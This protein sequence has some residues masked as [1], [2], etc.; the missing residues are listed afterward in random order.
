[1]KYSDLIH[2]EPIN[3][4]VKFSRTSELDYQQNLVKTFV[5]SKAY[6]ESLIP[7]IGKILDYTSN[8]EGFGM[9]VV[10]NYGT[11]KSHMMSLVSL[12]AENESLL[13]LV[14]EERPK[15]YLASFAGRYKV[16]R[17]ELGYTESLWE[18]LTYKI[19]NYL[20]TLGIDFS[21]EG[22]GVKSYAERIQLMMAEFEEHYPD[23]GFLVVIDEMLAYLK[24]RSEPS[25]L[26]QDLQV[27]QALGQAADA[28]KFR[29]IFGVQEMIYHSPEFQF[30]ADMLQKVRD[31]Y[32]DIIITKDDVSFIVKHRLLKKSEHQKKKIKD[33]LEPFLHLFTDMHGRTDEYIELFPVHPSY[34]ENFQKI[35]IG[36]SQREILKTLS[37]QFSSLLDE[38]IPTDHPGLICYDQYW[39]DI[40][41]SPDLMTIPDVRRV[42]EIS[43]TIFDKIDA[44]FIG[45]RT[46]RQS[47]AKRIGCA[48]AIKI[49]Q[50]ELNQQNGVNREQLVD[51][52]C[53]TAP[54]MHERELLIDTVDTT[55]LHIITATSGQFFD[56]NPDN[57]EYHLRIEGGIN[58][59]QKIKDYAATMS[60]SQKD[61]Y[62][63]KFLENILPLDHDPYRTGFKIWQHQIEW[64]SHKTYREG[65]IFFGDPNE[66]STT[67]PRQYFYLYFMPIFDDSKKQRNHEA[68][69][70]YF[71]LD[72]LSDEFRQEI[73]LY[74]AAM[75][76]EGRADTSQKD[77][78]KQKI[79]TLRDKARRIFEEEYLQIT[80][81]DYLGE[82]RPLNAFPLP[83]EGASKEHLF[84]EVAAQLLEN[85]FEETNP[86]YPRF[87]LLTASIAKDNFPRLIK[88]A[89]LKIAK[90]Q[91][92]NRDGEGI[93][94][95]LGLWQ[96]GK[97]DISQSIYAKSL[98]RKLQEKGEGKVLNREEIL[99]CKWMQGNLWLSKDF[100]I[101]AELEFLVMATLSALGEIEITFSSG[102]SINSTSLDALTKLEPEAFFTFSNI[103]APKEINLAAI[104]ALFL[105]LLGR[106]LS[107][108][109]NHEDTYI[110]LKHAC[111]KWS[112]RAVTLHHKTRN[113]LQ[114][115]GI[116]II[117]VPKAVELERKFIPFSRF[118]DQ[119]RTYDS[120]AKMKNFR[121]STE[122]VQQVLTS[123]PL[124]EQV[125]QQLKE[126]ETFRNLISY[127]NQ[128][129]QYLPDHELKREI[130]ESINAL[131]QKIGAEDKQITTTY[132]KKLDA[133]KNRYI[134][135]Y[136]NQY[137][138]HRISETDNTQKQALLDSDENFICNILK[139]ADFL[140]AAHYHSLIQEINKLEVADANFNK[141]S[142]EETPYQNFNPLNY[143]QENL[144]NI[145][146]LKGELHQLC[147]QWIETLKDTMDDPA[148]KKNISLLDS[149]KRLLLQAF[150]EG[151]Q[152]IN[153]NNVTR[154]RNALIELYQGLEKIELSADALKETFHKPLTPD[155]AIDAFKAYMNKIALGKDRN[156]IRIILK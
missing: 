88:Q 93:L 153:R 89:L 143:Q 125:E 37:R 97:L 138:I 135:Y 43:D 12:I 78:Y 126:V 112:K 101:E 2:F 73:N 49:L 155:E 69:E 34:F 56:Q 53:Y 32:R 30:A 118:C 66:K 152:Q 67:H 108:Y 39:L 147:S 130:S 115:N 41:A 139:D 98:K 45:A 6:Q 42:R 136:Y 146:T 36:K 25:K 70:V 76:L 63:F 86:D 104:R 5:F 47:L 77:I 85:N 72:G 133:L 64:K 122:E 9:Q 19:E 83:G 149:E 22:H 50:G 91:Q 31:R 61:E 113:G 23:K 128:S 116:P 81:V 114:L 154:I 95:G 119:V 3:E 94:S 107:A 123:K 51:D 103:K 28:S 16:L 84:S 27:L 124:I 145:H 109:L 15:K 131:P 92:P 140:P 4:V 79:R 96:P 82:H 99:E 38:D 65:Y 120:E 80:Q 68:D 148:V 142:L 52:L 1:M 74:G 151:N 102:Q 144:K 129:L 14:Q 55:A 150:K 111:E 132:R 48:A 7:L 59:D 21:F 29:I 137:L 156:K 40:A 75:A 87:N 10:G 121:F 100:K 26:N 17:F 58:F 35:R 71:I 57:G 18:I 8:Y 134:D 54:L 127:L 60:A 110:A 13:D 105:G 90:P 106:D 11:G 20:D 117:S 24:G 62:F 44:Y 46:S 33:H 141:T